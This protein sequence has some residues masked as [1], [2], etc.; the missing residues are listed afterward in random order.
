MTPKKPGSLDDC[1]SI[2]D[3]RE[4]ARRRLPARIF[5]Y[6]GGGAETEATV[7]ASSSTIEDM[8]PR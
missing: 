8:I 2:L 1:L 4:L 7:L 3:L 5:D 6:P